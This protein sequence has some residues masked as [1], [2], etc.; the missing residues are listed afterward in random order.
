MRTVKTTPTDFMLEKDKIR[1][2]KEEDDRK[3]EAE[4]LARLAA[5]GKKP[6]RK[7][8]KPTPKPSQGGSKLSN[9][10]GNSTLEVKKQEIWDDPEYKL[11]FD[12]L[13]HL[14][15]PDFMDLQDYA[16]PIIR[17]ELLLG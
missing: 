11:M 2:Q 17:I 4:K 3:L 10:D 12:K 14:K 13:P 7:L 16:N 15:H 6:P 5:K 9:K 8:T 1:L